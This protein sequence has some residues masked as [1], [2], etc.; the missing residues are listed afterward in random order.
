M[1]F[2]ATGT[3]GEEIANRA[4]VKSGVLLLNWLI[5]VFLNYVSRIT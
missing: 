2:L 4:F 1:I 3:L 5:P